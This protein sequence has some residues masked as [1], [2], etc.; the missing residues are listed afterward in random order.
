MNDSSKTM[1]YCK[2]YDNTLQ[3]TAKITKEQY[4]ALRAAKTFDSRQ[5]HYVPPNVD[6]SDF[7]YFEVKLRMPIYQYRHFFESDGAPGGSEWESKTNQTSR[8]RQL[9]NEMTQQRMK[10]KIRE[11]VKKIVQTQK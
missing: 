6:D 10:N 2:A 9:I 4:L 5:V 8:K 3:R 11:L 7:G 1:T